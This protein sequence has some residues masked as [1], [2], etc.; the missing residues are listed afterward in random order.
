MYTNAVIWLANLFL[1]GIWISHSESTLCTQWK[2]TN[3]GY[4][5]DN[6]SSFSLCENETIHETGLACAMW[7][8]LGPKE[9][10]ENHGFSYVYR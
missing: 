2:G 10:V 5:V 7:Y 1:T 3:K 6:E 8:G 4:I 9:S